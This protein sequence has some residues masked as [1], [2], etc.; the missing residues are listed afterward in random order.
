MHDKITSEATS[1]DAANLGKIAVFI[2]GKDLPH[3]T[4]YCEKHLKSV[5]QY[6]E[7]FSAV[8]E[9]SYDEAET[10]YSPHGSSDEWFDEWTDDLDTAG[11]SPTGLP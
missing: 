2:A 9:Y 10:M 8:P 6:A 5:R 4:E 3:G 11:D 1:A 7:V